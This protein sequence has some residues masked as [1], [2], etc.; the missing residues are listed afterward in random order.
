MVVHPNGNTST[1]LDLA[2]VIGDIS[3]V[4][5]VSDMRSP[6]NPSDPAER[7]LF[8]VNLTVLY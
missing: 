6:V 7:E 4:S 8:D 3:P 5:L 2:S 1:S